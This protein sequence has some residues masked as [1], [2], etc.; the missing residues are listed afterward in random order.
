MFKNT[1]YDNMKS[2]SKVA[3]DDPRV[4]DYWQEHYS[5]HCFVIG[6]IG[7]NVITVSGNFESHIKRGDKI[8]V[9]SLEEFK[10][11][12]SYEH[13]DGTWALCSKRGCDVSWITEERGE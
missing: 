5:W 6:R 11:W 3:I 10:K 1:A 2:L 9:R 8:E 4:G 12:L 13:I 7:K